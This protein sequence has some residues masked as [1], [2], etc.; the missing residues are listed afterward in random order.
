VTALELIK[1]I[2]V[3]PMSVEKPCTNPSNSEIRRWLDQKAVVI[4]GLRPSA[5]SEVSFPIVELVFFPSGNR[6]TTVI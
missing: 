6:R 3:V 2:G 1:H 4:N 5:S